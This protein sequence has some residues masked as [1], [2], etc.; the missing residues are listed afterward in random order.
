MTSG[1]IQKPFNPLNANF[2]TQIAD[3]LFECVWPPLWGWHLKAL[4]VFPR[5]KVPK[6][7]KSRGKTMASFPLNSL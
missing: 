7:Q 2:T 3:E 1:R 5:K 6:K 4:K